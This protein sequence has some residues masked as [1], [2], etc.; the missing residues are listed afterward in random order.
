[1]STHLPSIA[2]LER[3]GRIPNPG[4]F[5]STGRDIQILDRLL[6]LSGAFDLVRIV[7]YAHDALQFF[8][9]TFSGLGGIHQIPTP[10]YP[11][12]IGIRI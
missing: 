6:I 4:N 8:G 10:R 11:L 1:M 2:F 7:A 9:T 3:N 12:G 5:L